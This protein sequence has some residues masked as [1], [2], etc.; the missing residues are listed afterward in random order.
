M[1]KIDTNYHNLSPAGRSTCLTCPLPRCVHDE[2]ARPEDICPVNGA[3]PLARLSHHERRLTSLMAISDL[4]NDLPAPP[5]I[6][7]VAK[8]LDMR[9]NTIRAWGKKGFIEIETAIAPT[10]KRRLRL[11]TDV[12]L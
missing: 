7:E 5:T 8:T 9:A 4:L 3:K 10:G 6:T 2:D 12:N 1:A 11:I